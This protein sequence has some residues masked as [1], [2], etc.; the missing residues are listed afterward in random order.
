M[1][2]LSKTGNKAGKQKRPNSEQKETNLATNFVSKL[3]DKSEIISAAALFLTL[4]IV[5]LV[6]STVNMCEDGFRNG[7]VKKKELKTSQF[8]HETEFMSQI[9]TDSQLNHLQDKFPCLCRH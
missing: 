1:T 9:I 4:F 8:S 7:A 3:K 2:D 6:G 5:V